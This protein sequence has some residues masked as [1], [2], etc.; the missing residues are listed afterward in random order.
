MFNGLILYQLPIY[1]KTLAIILPQNI[2]DFFTEARVID[3]GT[4]LCHNAIYFY[5]INDIATAI[6]YYLK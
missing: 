1:R 2:Q 4:I 6:I 5:T 3:Y